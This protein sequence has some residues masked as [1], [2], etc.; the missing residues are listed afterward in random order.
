MV[1]TSPLYQERLT[2]LFVLKNITL[3]LGNVPPSSHLSL[4]P[5]LPL[6]SPA[7]PVEG[8]PAGGYLLFVWGIGSF[9]GVGGLPG[10]QRIHLGGLGPSRLSTGGILVK[11]GLG[12]TRVAPKTSGLQLLPG[13]W[14][15]RWE[16]KPPH[17]L[18]F[19]VFLWKWLF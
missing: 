16:L 6:P 10:P 15:R 8:G 5:L 14:D 3:A 12:P 19:F 9:M 2:T 4:P 7:F 13:A 18:L 11:S 17:L 1:L